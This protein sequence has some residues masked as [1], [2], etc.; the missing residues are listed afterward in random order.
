MV[1]RSLRRSLAGGGAFADG[2]EAGRPA[3]GF[4]GGTAARRG[5]CGVAEPPD[6]AG[7]TPV[8]FVKVNVPWHWGHLSLIALSGTALSST[9]PERPHAG[10][11]IVM[12]FM[13]PLLFP[14]GFGAKLA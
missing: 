10:Q 6:S 5:A 4:G 8:P 14:Q 12:R 3:L 13:P 7:A 9:A 11:V 2:A 1:T